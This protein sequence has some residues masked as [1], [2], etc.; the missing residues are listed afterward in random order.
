MYIVIIGAGRVGKDLA[1]LLLPEGHDVVMVDR[2][3]DVCENLT[4]TFDALIIC[5]DGTDLEY[6]K[7]AGMNKADAVALVTGDDKVNLIAAQLCMKLFKVPKI[8]ARVN[9]P[10]NEGVFANLGID[11]IVSTTRASAMQV[12][13]TLGD[14]RTILTVG[15][16]EAQLI[17]F[18]VADNA[19][20]AHKKIKAAGLPKGGIIVSVMRGDQTLIPDGETIIR[21]GDIVTILARSHVLGDIK[22]AFK[23]KKRFG[24]V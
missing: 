11:D 24:I 18:D 2:S 9:E 12:K 3:E 15:G 17:D 6:L 22:K 5:G 20:I 16:H 4:R 1:Q 13:N 23:E 10:K 8:I 7:D 19:P 14:S 21:P